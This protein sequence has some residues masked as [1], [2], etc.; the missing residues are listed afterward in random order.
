[1]LHSGPCT[2]QGPPSCLCVTLEVSRADRYTVK[3]A[4][5][6]AGRHFKGS[7]TLPADCF[8]TCQFLEM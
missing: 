7:K 1:M 3:D 6:L 4:V 5:R 8:A 2:A